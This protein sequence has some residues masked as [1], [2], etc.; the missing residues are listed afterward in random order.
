MRFSTILKIRTKFTKLLMTIRTILIT[1]TFV[2]PTVGCEQQ[3]RMTSQGETKMVSELERAK[4]I[5]NNNQ[6][7]EDLKD[8]LRYVEQAL[9]NFRTAVAVSSQGQKAELVRGFLDGTDDEK[10]YFLVC[11]LTA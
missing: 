8:A 5:L 11:E 3:T 7:S 9:A 2:Q 6:T 4:A 1:M 10:T